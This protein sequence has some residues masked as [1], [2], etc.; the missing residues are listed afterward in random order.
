MPGVFQDGVGVTPYGYALRTDQANILGR[1]EVDLTDESLKMTLDSRNRQGVGISVGSVFANTIL[2]RGSL[3]E[4]RIVP[5]TTSLLW[6]G[7][8]AFLTA[9]LSVVGESV[10][11]RALAS[12]NPCQSIKHLVTQDLCPKSEEAAAS[13][14]VCPPGGGKKPP[15]SN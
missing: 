13:T 3:A 5:N 4:P 9:G 1:I 2:V 10:I 7:G 6:R 12:E 14:L 15:P 11:K 8:A